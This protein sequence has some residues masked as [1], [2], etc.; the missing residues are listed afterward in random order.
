[1]KT[2]SAAVGGS[3]SLMGPDQ[4]RRVPTLE[5][6]GGVLVETEVREFFQGLDPRAEGAVPCSTRSGAAQAESQKFPDVF[7]NGPVGC[8]LPARHRDETIRVLENCMIS[9]DLRF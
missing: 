1:M 4:V 3:K 6:K 7:G 8:E 9:R 2:R 5:M